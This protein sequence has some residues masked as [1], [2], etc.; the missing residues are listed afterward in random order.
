MGRQRSSIHE[1]LVALKFGV[2]FEMHAVLGP[3][4][5][6]LSESVEGGNFHGDD[7]GLMKTFSVL[8]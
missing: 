2:P 3:G 7:R 5:E 8:S 6:V 4:Q 1:V